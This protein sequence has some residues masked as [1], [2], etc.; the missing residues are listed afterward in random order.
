MIRTALLHNPEE[1]QTSY[2]TRERV[3]DAASGEVQELD[4]DDMI[5]SLLYSLKQFGGE[6]GLGIVLDFADQLQAGR[7]PLPGEKTAQILLDTKIQQGKL[8]QITRKAEATQVDPEAYEAALRDARGGLLIK[9][10]RQIAAIATLG[11]A[12]LPDSVGVLTDLLG[13]KDPMTAGAAHTA[14]ACLMHP[15]PS[16][17][18]FAAVLD[19]IFENPKKLKGKTMDGLMEFIRREVPKNP[20]YDKIFARQL[21]INI[22]DEAQTH[23]LNGAFRFKPES[24]AAAAKAAAG[25]GAPDSAAEPG[26]KPAGISALDRRMA[27]MQARREWLAGGRKGPEPKVEG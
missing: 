19:R 7:L 4:R 5:Q 14:L 25:P 3:A 27:Q 15:L 11:S 20:P 13:D 24:S 9:K 22:D 21:A 17:S 26:E 1:K 10:P 18:E 16:E 6:E 12:R 8:G 23:Q 2:L